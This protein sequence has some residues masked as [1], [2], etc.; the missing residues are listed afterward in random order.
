MKQ[1]IAKLGYVALQSSNV[2]ASLHFFQ[3]V[4]GLELTEQIGDTYYLRAWGD[5]QHHTLSI[6][7]GEA[8]R[9]THIGFRT[10]RKED[11]ALFADQLGGKGYEIEHIAAWTAPGMG[12]AIRCTAL[13]GH[14]LALYVDIESAFVEE[15][16]RSVLKNQTY[17]SYSMGASPRRLDHTNIRTDA[18]SS[19]PYKFFT[20][21]PG[22]RINECT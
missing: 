16:R 8:G 13:S 6:A 14:R 9:V 11:V 3:D 18:D 1:A 21:E 2:E 22:F 17:K 7:P 5:F 19:V 4:I 15:S 12:E 10:K 20:E